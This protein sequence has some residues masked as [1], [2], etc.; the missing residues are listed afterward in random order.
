MSHLVWVTIAIITGGI[1]CYVVIR[2]LLRRLVRWAERR[3][4]H[5]TGTRCKCGYELV[6]LEIPRCPECGRAIGF[7]S[8]FE[9]LGLS[10]AEVQRLAE[11][12]RARE[13]QSG[14]IR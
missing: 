4:L 14:S 6:G 1:A 3:E 13:R 11:T 9:Q 5:Q 10:E 2:V 12:R 7:D 8:T